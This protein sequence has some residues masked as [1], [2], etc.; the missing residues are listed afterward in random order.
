M[1]VDAVRHGRLRSIM[2]FPRLL[3]EAAKPDSLWQMTI[4]AGILE[5]VPMKG[6]LFSYQVPS[7]YGMLCAGYTRK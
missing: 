4:L 6:E 3:V 2:R 1:A 5:E 7:Y